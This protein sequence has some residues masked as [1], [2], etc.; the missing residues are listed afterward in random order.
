MGAYE[1]FTDLVS[2]IKSTAAL[3]LYPLVT[4]YTPAKR[5]LIVKRR[6]YLLTQPTPNLGTFSAISFAGYS[7]ANTDTLDSVD[8]ITQRL[9]LTGTTDTTEWDVTVYKDSARTE[10]VASGTVAVKASGGAAAL[11]AENASGLTGS[12]TV[13]AAPTDGDWYIDIRSEYDRYDAAVDVSGNNIEGIYYLDDDDSDNATLYQIY[14]IQAAD[15]V[16]VDKLG[17]DGVISAFD[18][19]ALVVNLRNKGIFV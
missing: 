2:Q 8:G 15:G 12:I 19:D 17:V 9:Y 18:R 7:N 11:S 14:L 6:G 10:L 1:M 3:R 16:N 5:D 4:G 13:S